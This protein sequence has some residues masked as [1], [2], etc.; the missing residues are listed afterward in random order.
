MPLI[1][2][3]KGKL[4][5]TK[6]QDLNQHVSVLSLQL[7][8]LLQSSL[9]KFW[10]WRKSNCV[11]KGSDDRHSEGYILRWGLQGPAL[12]ITGCRITDSLVYYFSHL[13]ADANSGRSQL[14]SLCLYSVPHA[15][16]FSPLYS[17]YRLVRQTETFTWTTCSIKFFWQCIF[18]ILRPLFIYL[19]YPF[20]IQIDS[21][22]L[23]FQT[24]NEL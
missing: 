1:L 10:V 21:F 9:A 18:Y 3:N 14:A 13:P 2:S 5:L 4:L 20:F 23:I 8:V 22:Q 12:R 6:E 17:M 15:L 19:F 24:Q 16:D 11:M 7:Q